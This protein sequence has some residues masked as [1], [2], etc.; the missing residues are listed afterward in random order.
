MAVFS[1]IKILEHSDP[2]SQHFFVHNAFSRSFLRRRKVVL[3]HLAE[4]HMKSHE[5]ADIRYILFVQLC[6]CSNA[7]PMPK[8]EASHI[9]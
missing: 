9:A 3:C 2:P 1:K 4:W 7:A 8:F 6:D 5:F